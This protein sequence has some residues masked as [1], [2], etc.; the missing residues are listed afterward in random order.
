MLLL[1]SKGEYSACS[2]R[3]GRLQTAETRDQADVSTLRDIAQS[4]QPEPL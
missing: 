3:S 1:L 2:P 4:A